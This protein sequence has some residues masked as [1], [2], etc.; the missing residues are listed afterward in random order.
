MMP[1]LS[2]KKFYLRSTEIFHYLVKFLSR[3]LQ[4]SSLREIFP[5]CKFNVL[6][7]FRWET[8]SHVFSLFSRV[9]MVA[10]ATWVNSRPLVD[11]H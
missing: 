10:R 5:L 6:T 2:K 4:T 3:H 8:H 1:V 11:Y 7:H 9:Y